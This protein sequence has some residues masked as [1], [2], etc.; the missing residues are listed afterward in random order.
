MSSSVKT[1]KMATGRGTDN[2]KSSTHRTS[3]KM[4]KYLQN[5]GVNK[6]PGASTTGVETRASAMPTPTRSLK[7][8][9]KGNDQVCD[10]LYQEES[11][12]ETEITSVHS[13]NLIEDPLQNL[14]YDN[15]GELEQDCAEDIDPRQIVLSTEAIPVI[16]L[17]LIR[18]L[19]RIEAEESGIKNENKDLKKNINELEMKL[20]AQTEETKNVSV[21]LI[22]IKNVQNEI[23]K[24]NNNLRGSLDF[25]YNK[26]AVLEDSDKKRE[27]TEK[28]TQENIEYIQ[29]D[30]NRINQDNNRMKEKN[31]KAE[32]YSRRSNLRFEGI[33][34][35]ANETNVQCRNMVYDFIKN[36]MGIEN[37][38]RDF[39]IERCH[40][41]AKF[42]N[43]NPPSIIARFLSFRDRQVV[44]EKRR[45]VNQNRDNKFFINEDFPQEVERKRS[46]L[47]PYV[48]AAYKH[49]MKATLV[50]DTLLVDGLR[51]SVDDL[52]T[53]PEKI[54]PENTVVRTDGKVTVFFRKDAFMSNFHPSK[55]KIDNQEF[56]CVEQYYMYK[57]AGKFADREAQIKI[58]NSTNPNE[59]NFY[60]KGVK[61]F[62]QQKWNEC[63][64]NIMK[65]A[66]SA[67]F[68]QNPELARLLKRTGN[69]QIGEGS[70]KDLVWG[71]GI[72]VFHTD[73]LN[74]SKWRGNNQL[75]K[76]LMEVR[77][78]L[79][80]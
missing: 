69:T 68:S 57:K 8:K 66:V 28:K 50:G 63:S 70:E 5:I 60:G 34:K 3:P 48:K 52:N 61:K 73:A 64:Y 38:E 19:D 21:E 27:A 75:G 10:P 49:D 15:L 6:T 9:D 45:L 4:T 67:K 71:T 39:V 17:T 18:H 23:E 11:E 31:I 14:P 80:T 2:K 53:L 20:I 51:Y 65:T 29:G 32:A 62:Q 30:N 41:D 1:R 79:S 56:S 58:M 35:S 54:R 59:I 25:A 46:F 78:S 47:R 40:R 72:S 44:W 43:Q 76:I 37:A 55:M 13:E 26:I 16:L 33:P 36:E 22:K 24:E 7:E 74:T 42:P 77:E 12:S